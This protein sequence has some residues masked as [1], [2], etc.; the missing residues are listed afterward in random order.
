MNEKDGGRQYPMMVEVGLL[1]FIS[2]L[3]FA[4]LLILLL[5]AAFTNWQPANALFNGT[6]GPLGT[7]IGATWFLAIPFFLGLGIGKTRKG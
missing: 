6:D 2:Y 5:I 7:V 4:S 3:L 1:G